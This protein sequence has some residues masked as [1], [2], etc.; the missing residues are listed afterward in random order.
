MFTAEQ[1]DDCEQGSNTGQIFGSWH[2]LWFKSHMESTKMS[3]RRKSD[4]W[5]SP[6]FPL[7][8]EDAACSSRAQI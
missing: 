5:F 7:G 4:H 2:Y 6:V 3:V 8:S 1:V